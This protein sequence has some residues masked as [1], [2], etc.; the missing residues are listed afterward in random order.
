MNTSQ[1]RV[2]LV[3]L[4][5]LSPRAVRSDSPQWPSGTKGTAIAGCRASIVYHAEQDYLKRSNLKE[6]PPGFRE[7]SAP[8]ME[9]FLA[10][11]GCVFDRIEKEWTFEYFSA[12]QPDVGARVQE[13]AKRE[14]APMAK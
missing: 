9:P 5:V 14:C 3:A 10:M 4:L 7:K 1:A 8:I 6:L 13:L 12:H 2:L 11:C